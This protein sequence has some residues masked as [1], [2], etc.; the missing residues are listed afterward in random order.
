VLSALTASIQDAFNE[1]GV[2]IMSPYFVVQ[3]D[4]TVVVPKDQ[5]AP[6]PARSE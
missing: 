4:K 5:W 3:P 1:H 6:P 2:Q